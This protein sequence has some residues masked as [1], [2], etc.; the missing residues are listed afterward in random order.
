[1]NKKRLLFWITFLSVSIVFCYSFL[2]LLPKFYPNIKFAPLSAIK[3]NLENSIIPEAK[4]SAPPEETAFEKTKSYGELDCKN[5]QSNAFAKDML[6]RINSDRQKNERK[7]LNWS[8]KLCQ[9][10]KLKSEDM[11]SNNYFEHNSPSGVTP[12]YWIKKAGYDYAAVGENLALNY[13]TSESVHT[14]LMNSPGHRANILNS[15]F[16]EIGFY[17]LGGAFKDNNA[18]FFVEHFASPM[19]K[20]PKYVC[21]TDK[22]NKNL[23]ELKDTKNKIEKYLNKAEDIKKSLETS[24][25]SVKDVDNYIDDMEKKEKQADR[26]IQDIGDYLQK[27]KN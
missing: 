13:F 26:Y 10:A 11:N 2:V 25:Q 17:Y 3:S 20:I 1:M 21:E 7:P 27:C 18:F 8:E 24:G 22:A 9:S 16:T 12:W 15:D 4:I 6:E 14:A 23:K 5:Y 19:S